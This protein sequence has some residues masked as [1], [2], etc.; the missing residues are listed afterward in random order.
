MSEQKKRLCSVYQILKYVIWTQQESRDI[1]RKRGNWRGN[2]YVYT[3]KH[4]LGG[5]NMPKTNCWDDKRMI[6][7]RSKEQRHI[8]FSEGPLGV[9]IAEQSNTREKRTNIWRRFNSLILKWRMALVRK[10]GRLGRFCRKDIIACG[11]HDYKENMYAIVKWLS[12]RL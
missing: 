8:K 4:F 9:L 5:I 7:T 3:Q 2:F 6:K 1:N 11:M 10:M 12:V